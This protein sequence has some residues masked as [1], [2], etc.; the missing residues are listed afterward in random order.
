MKNKRLKFL[1]KLLIKLVQKFNKITMTMKLVQQHVLQDQ[2]GM[3]KLVLLINLLKEQLQQLQPI[4][5]TK[6]LLKEEIKLQKKH[7]LQQLK[8]QLEMMKLLLKETHNLQQQHPLQLKTLILVLPL[9]I[10][11]I[12]KLM[13]Q[14]LLQHKQPQLVKQL[15]QNI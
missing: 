8:H 10:Q 11:L 2:L 9:K 7:L 13:H 4:Q 14:I 3:E 5:E 6:H 1:Q 12:H 15:K